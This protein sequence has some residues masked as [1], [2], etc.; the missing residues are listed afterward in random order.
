[1]L[2]DLAIGVPDRRFSDRNEVPVVFPAVEA[3]HEPNDCFNLQQDEPLAKF[4][5]LKFYAQDVVFFELKNNNAPVVAGGAGRNYILDTA[6]G[7]GRPYIGG[8]ADIG[9]R[10]DG[11]TSTRLEFLRVLLGNEPALQPREQLSH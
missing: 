10:G 9:R 2:G 8:A 6:V 5:K 1:L 11:P 4:K 3:A 7:T